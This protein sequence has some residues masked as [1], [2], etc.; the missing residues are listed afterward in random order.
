MKA[1]KGNHVAVKHGPGVS[2]A[3]KRGKSVV[4]GLENSD[5]PTSEHQDAEVQRPDQSL[6]VSQF[7]FTGHWSF[8]ERVTHQKGTS[9]LLND[10]SHLFNLFILYPSQP[11]MGGC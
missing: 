2:R 1:D 5:L 4:C 3:S 11:Q 7:A 6:L 10:K 9:R 8:S